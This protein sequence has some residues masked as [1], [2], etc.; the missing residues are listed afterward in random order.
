MRNGAIVLSLV[1]IATLAT[2]CAMSVNPLVG[3]LYSDDVV[4]GLTATPNAQ[5]PKVGEAMQKMILGVSYGDGS[6]EAAAANG[7]ITKIKTVDLKVKNVLGVYME[8]T[9]IVTGE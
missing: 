4:G 2:G 6:I 3:V 8:T 9:T 1:L 5:G 7:G